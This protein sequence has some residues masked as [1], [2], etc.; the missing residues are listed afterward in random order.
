MLN[1]LLFLTWLSE[2]VVRNA[3]EKEKEQCLVSSTVKSCINQIRRMKKEYISMINSHYD[4][5]LSCNSYTAASWWHLYSV[6]FCLNSDGWGYELT[7]YFFLINP[8]NYKNWG[9]AGVILLSIKLKCSLQ[10]ANWICSALVYFGRHFHSSCDSTVYQS[11][12]GSDY[13]EKANPT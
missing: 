11:F 12:K 1:V 6:F 8:S 3:A 9:I 10:E 4:R 7:D 5:G 13:L 2:V